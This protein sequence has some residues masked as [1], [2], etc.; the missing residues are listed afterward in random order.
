MRMVFDLYPQVRII[1]HVEIANSTRLGL[2]EIAV[3]RKI[4][5]VSMPPTVQGSVVLLLIAPG[6]H[7][8]V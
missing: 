3:E 5:D 2:R 6:A 4:V 1:A 8:G 7:L